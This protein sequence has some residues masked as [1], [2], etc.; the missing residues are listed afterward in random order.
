MNGDSVSRRSFLKKSAVT[1]AG[2]SVVGLNVENAFSSS[3]PWANKKAINPNIPN[4]KVVSC[5]DET[6]VT[7]KTNALLADTLLKQNNLLNT[8]R[9]EFDLDELAKKLTSKT[10]AAS[11]WNTIFQKAESKQWKDIKVAIKVNCIYERI[12]PRPAIVGKVCKELIRIGVTAANITIYDACHDAS[13]DTKYTPFIGNGIPSGVKVQSGKGATSSIST[14]KGNLTCTS[15]VVNADILVNCAVNKGHSQTDKGGFTLSMKNHTG[16]MKFSC[17]SID[18]LIAENKCATIIGGEIPKQ[19]LCIVDSLWGA[20]NGP[21]DPPSLVTCRISMGTFGPAVDIMVARNIREKL[22]KASHNESAISKILTGF[23]YTESEFTWEEFTPSTT[24]IVVNSQ[25]VGSFK[26]VSFS[27]TGSKP[28]EYITKFQIPPSISDFN[29]EI[30]NLSGK[31]IQK[32]SPA[33]GLSQIVWDGKDHSGKL[34]TP[35]MY[36]VKIEA[37]SFIDAKPFSIVSR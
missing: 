14:D 15:V 10:D 9:V 26:E 7:D 16:T 12:M 17:P 37:S 22:L 5:F 27:I 28:L 20:K 31:V 11:A 32:L 25:V 35:G 1:A 23:G 3:S 33:K 8:A 19:Q 4:T 2:I 24:G 21:F 29:A 30:V 18:E 13:G 34:V 36:V 6:M